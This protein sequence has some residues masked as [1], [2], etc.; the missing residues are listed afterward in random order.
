MYGRGVGES[1]PAGR[2]VSIVQV[3]LPR[4]A[5]KQFA[6]ISG[7]LHD[8]LVMSDSAA[9]QTQQPEV[10]R[11]QRLI[12]P[13]LR[14]TRSRKRTLASAFRGWKCEVASGKSTRHTNAMLCHYAP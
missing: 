10:E 3:G 8:W 4:R 14:L 2:L 1:N 5:S 6:A 11:T 7:S 9:S 13:A 12:N